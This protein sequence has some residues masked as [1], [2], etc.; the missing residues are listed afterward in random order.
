ME[1]LQIRC[2]EQKDYDSAEEIMKEVQQLHIEWRPDIYKASDPVLP[3]KVF[4]EM[5]AQKTLLVAE[6]NGTVEGILSYMYRHVKSEKQVERTV[7]F[8]DDLAVKEQSRGKGIGSSLLAYI[9]EKA[10]REH[11]DG[12]ELQVNARNVKAKQMYEKNGFTEKSINMEL[13]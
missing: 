1:N 4:E 8:I 12:V 9:K 2:A 7:L 10:D 11:L 13:L 5:V 3:Q 6:V